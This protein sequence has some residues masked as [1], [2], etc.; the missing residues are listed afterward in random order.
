MTAPFVYVSP[1]ARKSDIP[2]ADRRALRA[3]LSEAQN[4]RCCYC[5]IRMT[6]PSGK[7][8]RTRTIVTI[9]HL[10]PA[11]AGGKTTWETC[12][13]ACAGCN[14]DRGSALGTTGFEKV[15]PAPEVWTC[16]KCKG[17]QFYRL[18][19]RNLIRCKGCETQW[20]PTSQTILRDRKL[21]LSTYKVAVAALVQT[22]TGISI[23]GLTRAMNIGPRS[24]HAIKEK[25]KM[26]MGLPLSPSKC[27]HDLLG[28][29][30]HGGNGN[31]GSKGFRIAACPSC[32]G[33][34]WGELNRWRPSAVSVPTPINDVAVFDAVVKELF[35][36]R[37]TQGGKS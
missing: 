18:K 21:P 10:I 36:Q 1:N 33:V 27:R 32:G 5:G 13:A 12:V 4:H 7:D 14:S 17:H 19:T 16:P 34:F 20:S 9:E 6:E 2:L 28:S 25:I 30:P 11:S 37:P 24:G 26:A 29:P 3:R 31:A 22:P 35:R 15:D 23:S 8:D